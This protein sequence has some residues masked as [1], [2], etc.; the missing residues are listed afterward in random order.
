MAGYPYWFL[1]EDG[2]QKYGLETS[3]IVLDRAKNNKQRFLDALS[4]TGIIG[5]AC[6]A[7]GV[8]RSTQ[9]QWRQ[10]DPEFAEAF[11]LAMQ[12]AADGLE[13]VARKR[14][15]GFEEPIVDPRHGVVWAREPGGALKLDDDFQPI[16]LTKTVYS[17]QLM[18]KMLEAKKAE[19]RTKSVEMSG[20]GGAPLPT[21]LIVK[22]V[23][24]DGNGRALVYD[25]PKE[26]LAS[27]SP[28]LGAIDVES[29][30]VDPLDFDPLED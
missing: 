14:A 13:A 27:P 30:E 2:V 15:V 25:T 7:S 3:Q 8:A 26:L 28:A 19:F 1:D 24:S 5:E 20:P 18:A 6:E 10:K 29:R 22:F 12:A 17:D 23:K 21:K 11:Q 9:Q 4:R 16:P